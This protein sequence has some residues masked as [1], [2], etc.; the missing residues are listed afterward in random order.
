MVAG[1]NDLALDT[2][3]AAAGVPLTGTEIARRTGID[4]GVNIS[5]TLYALNK[6]GRVA[7]LG[8]KRP[9][10]YTLPAPWPTALPP[11]A[12]APDAAQPQ[13]EVGQNT[14]SARPE[15]GPA[16][17][18]AS[19]GAPAAAKHAPEGHPSGAARLGVSLHND[20][21]LTI[22]TEEAVVELDPAQV[23]DL[24]DFL[25]LTEKAWRP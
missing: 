24:G 11:P 3:R 19:A 1:T 15:P 9:Y 6:Q 13:P 2:L 25:S 20:G 4:G 8:D 12:I 14:G 7:R 17:L 16:I 23:L 5:A 22:A 18:P 10:R 21:T